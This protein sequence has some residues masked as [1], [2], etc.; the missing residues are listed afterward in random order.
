MKLRIYTLLI[1]F[2]E[3]GACTAVITMT[4]TQLLFLPHC[5]KHFLLSTPTSK[6]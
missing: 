5:K 4:M 3:L 2:C 6:M 1:A